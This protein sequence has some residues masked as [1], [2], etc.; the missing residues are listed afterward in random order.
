MG[1]LGVEQSASTLLST[2]TRALC[3]ESAKVLQKAGQ[4]ILQGCRTHTAWG[5]ELLRRELDGKRHQAEQRAAAA[6][7]AQQEAERLQSVARA[8]SASLEAKLKAVADRERQIEEQL[9]AREQ[10]LTQEFARRA[11]QLDLEHE[12]RRVE[13]Q[14]VMARQEQLLAY[15]LP[16]Q[17]YA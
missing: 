12:K 17:T 11:Q 10:T 8:Q 7:Q 4:N 3:F 1:Q 2:G 6:A 14:E 13:L 9:V 16:N 5:D 15:L